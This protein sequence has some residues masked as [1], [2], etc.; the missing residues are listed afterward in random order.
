MDIDVSDEEMTTRRYH[1]FRSPSS[2]HV[3]IEFGRSR[4][5]A[6]FS[7]DLTLSIDF[8]SSSSPPPLMHLAEIHISAR[9][10]GL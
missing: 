6:I 7:A 9:V 8:T 4:I 2:F 10:G 1:A 3:K 5:P